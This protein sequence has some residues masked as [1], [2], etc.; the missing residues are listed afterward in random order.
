MPAYRMRTLEGGETTVSEAAVAALADQVSGR[1]VLPADKE[2]DRARMLWNAMIDKRPGI[3]VRC[4]DTAHVI[5]AVNFAREHG[6]LTAIRG[7]GH[8]VA[9]SALCDGGVVIDLS[10][11]R[12][13]HV[14]PQ[15][16]VARVQGGATLG[17]LD[18]E[19]AAFGLA[20]PL[21]L[22]SK[23]GVAGLTLG[24]GFGWLTRRYGLSCDNL[25][26][27]DIV[28]A[29]GELRKASRQEHPDLFWALRGG[30]G[31]FGVVTSFEYD[32]Y[33]IGPTVMQ[34]AVFYPIEVAERG[35]RFFRE[36][37]E[38][39][40]DEFFGLGVLWSLPEGP[41]FP[42]EQQGDPVLVFIGVY[43]GDPEE[44]ERL[45]EPLRTFDQPLA[46]LSGPVSWI[47]AQTFFDPD[48]PDGLHYY[49][50]SAF[51]DRI[52]DEAIPVLVESCLSRP[53]RLS[54]VDVWYLGGAL[55][56]VDPQDAA[57]WA[58]DATSMIGVEANWIEPAQSEAN[59]AWARGV[60]AA[61][62]PF[63]TGSSYTNFGGLGVEA[64][65]PVRRIYGGNFERLARI[66]Q[67][68]D[69]G[70]LFRVNHNIAPG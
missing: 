17:D 7:G 22:V 8:N 44:G 18:R 30:G 48:Y 19:T 67:T 39:A 64:D 15:A 26:S 42:E 11:M 33:P 69:P 21:G 47:E 55:A 25:R 23:T 68:Y 53:S 27:M 12:S 49:W 38:R 10:E 28:T 63:A 51:L 61:L 52:S 34:T 29:D 1:V 66:K 24:G 35:L 50:K 43:S 32:L 13:V 5:A 16:R 3:I 70:N 45:V 14:D 37:M 65:N 56:R 20:T 4:T 31:N 54:T 58:R 46:D 41:D 57:F 6:L 59:I 62:Q 36:F 40:P 9:G 60:I 2:Y